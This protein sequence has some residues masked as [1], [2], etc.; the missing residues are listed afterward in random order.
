MLRS[1]SLI[2]SG[3]DRSNGM[4]NGPDRV[5]EGIATMLEPTPPWRAWT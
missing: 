1:L 5:R 4:T 3:C 2:S